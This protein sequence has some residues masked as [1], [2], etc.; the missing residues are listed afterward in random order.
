MPDA[1]GGYFAGS[2][3]VPDF[4]QN[5]GKHR[6]IFVTEPELRE[7]IQEM[8]MGYCDSLCHAYQLAKEANPEDIC[9]EHTKGPY[10]VLGWGTGPFLYNKI[11]SLSRMGVLREKNL[12]ECGANA[13]SNFF[14]IYFC[15]SCQIYL[16]MV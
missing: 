7:Q 6:V 15:S 1:G 5:S 3:A 9:S 16:M 8:K 14:I 2:V 11:A 13:F 10:L 4:V 12:F